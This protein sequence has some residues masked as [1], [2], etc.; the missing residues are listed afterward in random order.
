MVVVTP[1]VGAART[2]AAVEV[3]TVVEAVPMAASTAAAITVA[4]PRSVVGDRPQGRAAVP[5][6]H[7]VQMPDVPGLG[8]VTTPAIRLQDGINLRRAVARWVAKVL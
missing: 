3:S 6:A 1:E 7:A 4:V 5:W 8:K 2:L